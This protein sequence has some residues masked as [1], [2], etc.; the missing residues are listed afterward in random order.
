[1]KFSLLR[2]AVYA[3]SA[4]PV[5]QCRCAEWRRWR[6]LWPFLCHVQCSGLTL[7][8]GFPS[9]LRFVSKEW[10]RA[11]SSP[12][13]L[14]RGRGNCS[15]PNS[16]VSSGI[17]GQQEENLQRALELEVPARQQLPFWKPKQN[18]LKKFFSS[19]PSPVQTAVL[20][21]GRHLDS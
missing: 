9:F 20:L 2:R 8:C 4:C 18:F 1:M 14:G 3:G 12:G 16:S 7:C 21:S 17:N 13:I 11:V 19:C 5:S 10:I 15:F 6:L